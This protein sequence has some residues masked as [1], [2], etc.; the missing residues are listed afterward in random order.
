M[1]SQFKH[2][3]DD[4]KLCTKEDRI[5]LAVSGGVDSMAMLDLFLRSGFHVGVGHCNFQL[6]GTDSTADE[7]LVERVCEKADVPFHLKRFDTLDY[8]QQTGLSVQGAARQLRYDWFDEVI[9][10]KGYTCVATAHHLNDNLETTII[11][12]VRGSGLA[13]LVGIP[14][15]TSKII[16]PLIDFNKNEIL[17]Y[18][19]GNQLE[20]R[21]D[22]SN[23]RDDYDRNFIRHQIVPLLKQ[24]NSGLE[25]TFRRTNERL[26]GAEDLFQRQ[27][28]QIRDQYTQVEQNQFTI[29]KNIIVAT[30]FPQVVLWELL[31]GFG[32]NYQQACDAVTISS[33]V[34]G[35]KFLSNEFQLTIDRDHWIVSP[36][37]GD[38]FGMVIEKGQSMAGLNGQRLSVRHGGVEELSCDSATAQLDADTIQFPITWRNWR[39]GDYFFPLGMNHRKKVSDFLIDL[40]LPLPE[41]DQVTVLESCGEIIWIVGYRI[42]DRYKITNKTTEVAHFQLV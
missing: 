37:K 29:D 34:S 36:R 17:A 28:N 32:F 1:L 24:L 11:N 23:E 33:G 19:K 27:L 22:V 16:R 4:G 15:K 38:D 14:R 3:L 31:K 2:A 30:D 26:L 25:E 9:D 7:E 41:K 39:P 8:C 10:T 35:R 40:K 21:E 5:L 6:R 20:W 13:G 18:A 12:L 42:D